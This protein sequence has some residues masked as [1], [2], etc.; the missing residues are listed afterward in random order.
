MLTRI[1]GNCFWMAR[2]L[3]R[4]ENNARL[5]RMAERHACLPETAE[6]PVGLWS[7]A[8]EVGGTLD[9]YEERVGAITPESVTRFMVLDRNN[10]SAVVSCLRGARDNARTARHLL[11][12]VLWDTMNSTWIEAQALDEARLAD[13]ATE[14]VVGWTLARCRMI[15]GC[16]G[17]LWRD[18]V[19]HV[20]DLGRSI[21]RA[22]FIA[23]IL[24][25]MLPKLLADGHGP[26]AIGAPAGRRWKS[27]LEGLGLQESWRRVNAGVLDP[28]TVL[29]L[30]LLHPTAP[31]GM[32]VNVQAMASAISGFAPG[33]EGDALKTAR[34]IEARLIGTDLS[35]VAGPGMDGFCRQLTALTNQL[36]AEVQRDHFG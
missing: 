29:H 20:I 12:D 11:P 34:Q 13:L 5:L 10:P 16:F 21:E 4:A 32:L 25:E 24:A 33:R 19:P 1:A 22:D 23:R 27:L 2:Y 30:I 9:D 28:L 17:E 7:T 3:E 15:D 14:G 26:T 6:D 35:V 36:G 18:T 31:H 8:L